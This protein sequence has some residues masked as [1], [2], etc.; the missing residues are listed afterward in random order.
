[1]VKCLTLVWELRFWEP[2]KVRSRRS[3]ALT[4]EDSLRT[5]ASTAICYQRMA[6][7]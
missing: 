4:E 3:V 2:A 7:R 5:G 6:H 1:M